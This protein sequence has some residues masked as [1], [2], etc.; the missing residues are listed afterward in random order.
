MITAER[1][2]RIFRNLAGNSGMLL[3]HMSTDRWSWAG[4]SSHD[5]LALSD[6]EVVE[7]WA[8][9]MLERVTEKLPA[10]AWGTCYRLAA[11]Y[12]PPAYLASY[13]PPPCWMDDRNITIWNSWC[14]Q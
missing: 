9:G 2:N 5:S 14:G 8:G 1:L 3:A 12:I 6:A 4:C 11:D 10:Y 7:L 13:T